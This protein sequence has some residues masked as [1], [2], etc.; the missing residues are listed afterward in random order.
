[1]AQ[2]GRGF[3]VRRTSIEELFDALQGGDE[4]A[5]ERLLPPLRV[6]LTRVAKRRLGGQ[7]VEDVVQET[8]GTLW[9]KRESIRERRHLLPFILQILRNKIG[10]TYL[11]PRRQRGTRSGEGRL[12]SVPANPE[13]VHPEALLAAAEFD[14]I[15]TKAVG[16]CAAENPGFG[17]ILRLLREGRSPADI[18]GELGSIP[19]GAVRT[20]ICR[21]RQRLREVLREDFQVDL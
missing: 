2:D 15:V 12:E 17:E 10:N 3:S 21:A 19:M 7:D 16:K 18:R 20:R 14:D 1:M 9:K 5:L 11:R 4:E 6:T 13:T 8:L